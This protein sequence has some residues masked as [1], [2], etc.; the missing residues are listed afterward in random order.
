[1]VP[2]SNYHCSQLHPNN[3]ISPNT[4]KSSFAMPFS[5]DPQ[6]FENSNNLVNTLRAAAGQPTQEFRPGKFFDNAT[7]KI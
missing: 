3:T 5:K 2:G 1:M 6:I 7:D 4:I